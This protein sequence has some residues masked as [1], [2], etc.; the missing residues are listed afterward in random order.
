VEVLGKNAKT[1]NVHFLKDSRRV[2]VPI[3]DDAERAALDTVEWAVDRIVA[4]DFP[5]RPHPEKCNG[6]RNRRPCDWAKICP[7]VP[8]EF[9]NGNVPPA[10]HVPRPDNE[11]SILAFREYDPAWGADSVGE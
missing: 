3:A 5:M 6:S 9:A 7:K 4:S 10:I 2:D 11:L 8:R 1:G